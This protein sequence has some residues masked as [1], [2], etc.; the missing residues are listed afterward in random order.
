MRRRPCTPRHDWKET[1]RKCGFRFHTIEGDLYWDESACYQFTLRE[2]EQDIEDPTLELHGMC[3]DLVDEACH[4]QELMERLAIPVPHRD[5]VRDSWLA[6][7]PHLYGRMDFSY[8]GSGPAKL[9]ELNYDTPTA[10]YESAF[11]QWMWLE[12]MVGRRELPAHTDQYNRL[13]EDLIEVFAHLRE[14]LGWQDAPESPAFVFSAVDESEEDRGTVQYLQDLASQAGFRT[15]YLPL[16]QIGIDVQ[17]RFTDLDEEVIQACFK[18]YPWEDIFTDEYAKFLA[19][20]PTLMIEPP[21]KAILS[22]KGILPLL[23]E[24]HRGHPNLLPTY[25]DPEP[26]AALK[27]GWVRK[28]FFSREGANIQLS[29]PSG[30]EMAVAG[31]YEGGPCIL[32]EYHPLPSFDGRYAVIGSWMIADRP[33]G[34]GV[35]EDDT[36]VTRDTS[37][38]VPHVI[39]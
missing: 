7:E 35:R 36:L 8:D 9:Y 27:S 13:Q 3:L 20:S 11:F 2:I 37:R 1:A 18:L 33:S 22:N 23:W 12:E 25:F 21:W 15:R 30:R 5:L 32:Q 16:D 19:K 14:K 39:L 6:R 28:P 38:F 31:P 29:M 17:G 24:R 34:L 26:Q 4:S 10:L